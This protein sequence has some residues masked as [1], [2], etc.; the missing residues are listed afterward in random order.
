MAEEHVHVVKVVDKSR[1]DY[2]R[3]KFISEFK[4]KS[5]GESKWR[6]IREYVL[7]QPKNK[8]YFLFEQ[9][10]KN[11]KYVF[12]K[13]LTEEEIFE[14]LGIKVD[15]DVNVSSENKDTVVDKKET[16]NSV[17]Y[18]IKGGTLPVVEITLD[19]DQKIITEV[20]VMNYMSGDVDMAS[21]SGGIMKG[22]LTGQS[23]FK[24][25][26]TAKENNSVIAL[27]KDMPGEIKAIKINNT[28][29]FI[30]Q[31]TSLLGYTEGINVDKYIVKNISVGLFGG[32][33]FFMQKFTG[34][35]TVFIQCYGSMQMRTL[36]PGEKLVIDT[37]KLVACEESCK[38]SV[39]TVKGLGNKLFG[40]FGFFNTVC[41]G[42]GKVILQSISISGL[43]QLL[44]P[45][46]PKTSSGK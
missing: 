37:G 17:K 40:G 35:G 32:E 34:E 22:L 20:G 28:S 18:D 38:I 19:K 29:P 4:D 33:G 11:T 9:K 23:L 39:E 15:N 43:A 25:V 5:K 31:S 7:S 46:M 24:N 27:S 14:I 16:N 12:Y 41:I 2:D 45:F 26:F 8:Q 44:Y 10:E 3:S 21:V 36:K 13:D 1:V 42:P 30:C 6:E